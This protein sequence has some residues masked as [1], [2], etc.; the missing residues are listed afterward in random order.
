M[1]YYKEL[2]ASMLDVPGYGILHWGFADYLDEIAGFIER[3]NGQLVSRQIIA[4]AIV[5]WQRMNPGEDIMGRAIH[6]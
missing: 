6:G 3:E 1:E 2:A 5:T 4:M